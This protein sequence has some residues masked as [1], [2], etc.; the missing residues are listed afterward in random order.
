MCGIVLMMSDDKIFKALAREKAFTQ[1]VIIDT[2][3]GPHS[4]GLVYADYNGQAEV[5]K[6]PIPGY[7]F[8]NM[9]KYN[10][11]INDSE[12]YPFLIAHNRWATQGRVNTSNAHP[13]QHE[14]ITGVHNGSLYTWRD[15]APGMTFDTDSEYIFHALAHNDTAD[16]LKK[17]DGAFALVW[18]DS[19]DNTIHIARNDDRPFH[20][21][22]IKDSKTVLGASEMEM[23]ELMCARNDMEIEEKY[24]VNT[25]VELVFKLDDLHSPEVIEREMMEPWSSYNVGKRGTG[26]GTT[27]TYSHTPAKVCALNVNGFTLYSPNGIYGYVGGVD[28]DSE[29]EIRV[30]GYTQ[31]EYDLMDKKEGYFEA[32]VASEGRDSDGTKYKVANRYFMKWLT[33]KEAFETLVLDDDDDDEEETPIVKKSYYSKAGSKLLY[34]KD[35]AEALLKSGCCTCGD[36]MF[37]EQFETIEWWNHEPICPSCS[38]INAPFMI[39]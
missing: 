8:V 26:T 2:L 11:V 27:G 35:A 10:S 13:F 4:T 30:N 32:V 23:L 33:E 3:R 29:D 34:T 36:P 39:A 18:H 21:A 7:D 15:L 24:K 22:H 17:I 28:I 6:K 5:Y 25:E 37:L 16:V 20:L 31:Q 12:D 38:D 9:P 14:H 19:R 1:G